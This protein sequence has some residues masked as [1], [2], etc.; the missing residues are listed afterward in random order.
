VKADCQASSDA[1]FLLKLEGA[2][3][4][5]GESEVGLTF[6]MNSVSELPVRRDLN[7]TN[8]CDLIRSF[9]FSST[10]RASGVVDRLGDWLGV[11]SPEYSRA[12]TASEATSSGTASS[13]GVVWGGGCWSGGCRARTSGKAP[14]PD[15]PARTREVTWSARA[16]RAS[17]G[18]V[19][20]GWE[21]AVA[22][23]EGLDTRLA[24]LAGRGAGG[25]AAGDRPRPFVFLAG[26]IW[27]ENKKQQASRAPRRVRP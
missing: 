19:G 26:G 21:A 25:G 12:F 27:G 10:W 15:R 14:D 6:M 11:D 17:S 13:P 24:C 9:S 18:R 2:S 22:G 16:A 5:D 23:G 7:S 4:K 1:M 20:V 8:L 3:F